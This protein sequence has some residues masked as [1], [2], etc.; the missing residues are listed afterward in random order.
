MDKTIGIQNMALRDDDSIVDNCVD[1]IRKSTVLEVIRFECNHITLADGKITDA[2][3]QSK[4]PLKRL[5]LSNNNI[6][7]EGMKDEVIGWCTQT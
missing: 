1:I 4:A 2:I 6:C 7:D 5:D 3:A